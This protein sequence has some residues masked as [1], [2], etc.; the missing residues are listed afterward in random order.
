MRK[1]VI[2]APAQE[3]LAAI[4]GYLRFELGNVQAAEH[5]LDE[6]LSAYDAVAE[7]P[8]AYRFCN[9]QALAARG[10]RVIRVMRY[11]MLYRFEAD[12]DVV[13]VIRFFHE[14]QDYANM[15]ID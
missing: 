1:M 7:N 9:D 3:D 2:A 13:H 8:L 4:D 11:L 6:V 5:F 14:L 15:L 12:A 10:Y